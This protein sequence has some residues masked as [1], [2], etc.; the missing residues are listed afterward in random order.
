M[1]KIALSGDS[2]GTGT[3]TIASPNSNSNLTLTLPANTGTVV[4]SGTTPSLNGITFPATQV[5]SAGAN[6]LDDYE[7]GSW[8]PVYNQEGGNPTVTYDGTF[9]VYRKIGSLV[10]VAGRIATTS[11]TGGSGVVSIAGLPFTVEN[12]SQDYSALSVGV[13]FATWNTNTYP[14]GGY[15]VRNATRILLRTFNGSDARGGLDTQ[16]TALNASAAANGLVFSCV[17]VAA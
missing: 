6:T 11:V 14:T 7:E 17:Y 5:A 10:W 16:I 13:S 3:F 9:G 15:P 4:V 1:S 2:S 8:T 12:L